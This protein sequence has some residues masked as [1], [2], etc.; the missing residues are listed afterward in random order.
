MGKHPGLYALSYLFAAGISFLT[1]NYWIA[2]IGLFAGGLGI[3]AEIQKR[4]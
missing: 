2:A 3:G 1:G 4:A